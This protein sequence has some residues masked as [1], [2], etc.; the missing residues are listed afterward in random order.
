MKKETAKRVLALLIC[1]LMAVTM[2]P[3]VAMAEELT[4]N[5]ADGSAIEAYSAYENE[6]DSD[7][8]VL[9]DESDSGSSGIPT[10]S[11]THLTL[12]TICSV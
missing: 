6:N 8:A 4:N 5:T 2:L 9:D 11:Y 1:V 7:V 10:V 3:T 12:P